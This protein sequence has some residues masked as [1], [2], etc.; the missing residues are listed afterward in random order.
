MTKTIY[1]YSFSGAIV[2]AEPLP[3]LRTGLDDTYLEISPVRLGHATFRATPQFTNHSFKKFFGA[4]PD[5][6]VQMASFAAPSTKAGASLSFW[7]GPSDEPPPGSPD[8]PLDTFIV[9]AE[10]PRSGEIGELIE[11][12]V[13]QPLLEWIRVLTD[14]WW[15]GRSYERISGPLHFVA[16]VDDAN[17]TVGK[18]SPVAAM[19]TAGPRMVPVTSKIWTEAAEN[20]IVGQP[21]AERGLAT[22]AKYF[23]V[24]KEY[25]SGVI[26]ACC[27]FEAARDKILDQTGIRLTKLGGYD[28]RKH[29]SVGFEQTL[30]R[31]L[32]KENPRLADLLGAYWLAR[33]AAAHGQSVQWRLGGDVSA[34]D[35]V[36]NAEFTEGIDKILDWLNSV[37]PRPAR[38]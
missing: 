36:S 24:S 14:Q 5:F 30:G 38:P 27:A 32:A 26:L 21:S 16:P 8:L 34:I 29:L 31:N 28:L 1:Y 10:G 20:A 33:H 7:S 35:N 23:F 3:I 15:V 11:H 12:H 25:R 2:A 19:S 17:R 18:P 4:P 13:L 37:T 6:P 22:D 9:T